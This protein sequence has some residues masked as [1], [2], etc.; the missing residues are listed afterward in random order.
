MSDPQYDYEERLP[1]TPDKEI[2][3]NP[4]PL[5]CYQW[6]DGGEQTW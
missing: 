6:F 4:F 5:K 2:D 1:E 3:R